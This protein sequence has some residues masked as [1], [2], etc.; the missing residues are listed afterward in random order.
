MLINKQDFVKYIESVKEQFEHYCKLSNT[1][2][3]SF[4]EEIYN[5]FEKPH[6]VLSE[7]LF[8][9][10]QQDMV[11]WWLWDAPDDNKFVSVLSKG[12]KLE[13]TLS[14]PEELYDF[15]ILYYSEKPKRKHVSALCGIYKRASKNV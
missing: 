12:K 11:N 2:N 4:K 6:A 5:A 3:E 10:E 14:T 13:Y 15:L 8:K 7:V 1:L 9:K